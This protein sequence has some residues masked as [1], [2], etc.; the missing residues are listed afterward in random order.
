MKV[1]IPGTLLVVAVTLLVIAKRSD[2]QVVRE[3]AGEVTG[4]R[5]RPDPS[6]LASRIPGVAWELRARVRVSGDSAQRIALA[7]FE[8]RGRV[9]SIEI[10]EEDS[11][12]FWD[13]KILPD[14]NLQTIVRYRVD[15]ANGGIMSIKEFTGLRGLAR[16]P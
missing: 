6:Q 10:D 3:S 8:W 7:D 1:G 11:R 14:A 4:A 5:T 2:A 16:R 12:V 15:A 13:V 9:S